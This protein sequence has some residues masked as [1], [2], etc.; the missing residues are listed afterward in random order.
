M[1]SLDFYIITR[2]DDKKEKNE[3]FTRSHT[4]RKSNGELLINACVKV[5]KFGCVVLVYSASLEL[6]VSD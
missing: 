2:F 1:I 5:S 3:V 6:S 4:C